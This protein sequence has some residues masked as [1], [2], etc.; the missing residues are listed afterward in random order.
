MT[1]SQRIANRIRRK[2]PGWV[3][4][5]TDFL[6]FGTPQAIGMTLLRLAKGGTVRRLGRGL[7]DAPKTHPKLGP[8]HARPEAILAAVSRREGTDFQEHEAYAANRLGLSEQVPARLIYLTPGRSHIV[9]AGPTTIELRHRTNR[10]L[11]APH[12]MSATVFAALRNIGKA[13]I[14]TA[15]IDH[16]RELLRPKD[17]LNLLRDLSKAPA[18]MHPFLRHIAE[19]GIRTTSAPYVDKKKRIEVVLPLGAPTRIEEGNGIG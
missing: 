7:Y 5:P 10:K 17:R 14:T 4:T 9:K 6:D 13:N 1:T 18:W 3:F 2:G 11:T 12:R 8:L 19:N 16:L 15:R